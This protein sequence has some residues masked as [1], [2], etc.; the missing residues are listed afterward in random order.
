MPHSNE[1]VLTQKEPVKY[2]N[3]KTTDIKLQNY[4]NYKTTKKLTNKISSKQPK[5]YLLFD[6]STSIRGLHQKKLI[7]GLLLGATSQSRAKKAVVRMT[8]LVAPFVP[9]HG[10]W[11]FLPDMNCLLDPSGRSI[12]LSKY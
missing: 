6:V 11:T 3:K 7:L 5:S 2:A 1:S 4:E 12:R 9:V 8:E 10:S